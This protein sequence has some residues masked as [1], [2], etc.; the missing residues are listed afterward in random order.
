M[1]KRLDHFV[2]TT[3]NLPECI[4]FYEIL[5]FRFKSEMNKHAFYCE[6]FKINVHQKGK[7]LQPHARHIQIGSADF[8]FELSIDINE[9]VKVLKSNEIELVVGPVYRS[10]FKGLMNSIYI[11]DPDGNLIELSCYI[12]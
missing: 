3:D 2:I 4:K 5:G 8:C 10:G 6:S 12:I 7:E 1:I 11:Y 9:C